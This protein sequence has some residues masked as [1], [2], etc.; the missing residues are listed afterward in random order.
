MSKQQKKVHNRGFG[1]IRFNDFKVKLI[2]VMVALLILPSLVIGSLASY[3]AQSGIEQQLKDSATQSVES[4]NSL[5]NSM[6]NP[7][8]HDV[9]YFAQKLN[10]DDIMNDR[11]AVLEFFNQYITLHPE[12][13]QI[14]VGTKD[15][16]F[17]NFP[18]NKMPDDFDPRTRGWYESAINEKGREIINP[19]YH[20][21][22]A[23]TMV[24]AVSRAIEDGSG[25]IGIDLDLANLKNEVNGIKIGEAG[26]AILLDSNKNYILSPT[27]E[28]GET[29]TEEAELKMFES[30]SGGY[31]YEASGDK[32]HL[33]YITNELTG[34]KL[35]GTLYFS[36]VDKFVNPI[37]NT[38]M[39]TV[40]ICLVVGGTFLY[41]M[42][43]SIVRPI[44]RLAKL[45]GNVSEGDLT[46]EITVK[47][48]DEIGQLGKAFQNMQVK[49]RGL[50][51][52]VR[53][54]ADHVSTSSSE[55]TMSAEQTSRASQQVSEAVQEI[56][57]G[58]EKQTVGLEHN[59]VA[60]EEIAKGVSLIAE[61]SSAVADLAR[62]SSMHA[63]EG[64]KSLE[65]AGNQMHSIYES[66]STSN[67]VLQALYRRSQEIGEITGVISNI[68]S[69]TNLLALNA[70]IEAARAGEHGSGFAVVAD[71]VRKL[72]EQSEE[73]AKQI[74][75]LITLVQQD[76]S[77][78]VK[79]MS[80]ATLDVEEGLNIS[81]ITMRKLEGTLAGIQETSP[82]IEEIAATAQEISASVEEMTATANELASIAVG[83]AATSEEVA[84]STEEQLA[85]MQQISAS[86]S[87][88]SQM[89]EDLKKTIGLFKL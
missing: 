33:Q 83:N 37:T 66:V 59:S 72:A 49:L 58:A 43:K 7:K 32:K 14:Y 56:A 79:T 52:D 55:L 65:Q 86:A 11:E 61:R 85:S 38:T 5:I 47:S 8:V 21:I 2:T 57:S 28:P 54:S 77:S 69:Q 63:E 12:V 40:F 64:G 46:Q 84:A 88:L 73:S 13:S 22:G 53:T 19:P 42:V 45:A 1:R 67:E 20:S 39:I 71:E 50:I 51:Q 27:K 76:T 26:Y 24:V 29:A 18:M 70:A 81:A 80:Q 34:W 36:E 75:A 9:K 31:D 4:V 35:A 16:E 87:M 23:G 60:I 41:L 89:A 10:Q 17:I 6:M 44:A 30:E 78:A 48:E 74:T 82:Q 15:G 68:A 62:T 25:V 3:S